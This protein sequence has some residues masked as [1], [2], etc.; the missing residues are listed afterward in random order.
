M[1]SDSHPDF[2]GLLNGGNEFRNKDYHLSQKF[3][4]LIVNDLLHR[5][6]RDIP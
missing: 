2:V 5:V 6:V 3:L 4:H 1:W